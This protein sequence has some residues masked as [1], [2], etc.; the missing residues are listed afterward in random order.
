MALAV[1]ADGR[2]L[3]GDMEQGLLARVTDG[4]DWQVSDPSAVMG[5]AV[6]PD[7]ASVV[8][9]AGEGILRSSDG[10]TTWD[11]VF[12][13]AEGAGPVAWSASDPEV[14]YV[15]G[16]DR[17]LYRTQDRGGSWQPVG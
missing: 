9:A 16:F 17:V 10:G 5:L 7:D 11:R 8:I 13:L 2:L 1:T 4:R 6:N 3:A 12:P 15:V 14:G